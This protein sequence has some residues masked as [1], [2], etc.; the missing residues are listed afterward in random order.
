MKPGV[1]KSRPL[2]G[3]GLAIAAWALVSAGF[4][5]YVANIGRYDE[6]YGSLAGAVVFVLWLFL[7][8]LALLLGAEVDAELERGRQLQAGIEAEAQLRL[9]LRDA[10]GV[11]AAEE[12][13]ED[14]LRRGRELRETRGGTRPAGTEGTEGTEG[15]DGGD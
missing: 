5:F 6:V 1:L 3:Y 10:S 4:G 7:T 13:E 14:Y 12:R 2:A 15:T 9:P 8:N 11:A